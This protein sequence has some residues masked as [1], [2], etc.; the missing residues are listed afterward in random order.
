MTI[1]Q[2]EQLAKNHFGITASAELLACEFGGNF[3][4]T[5]SSGDSF[6]L[7][8]CT[9]F[10]QVQFPGSGDVQNMKPGAVFS[11]QFNSKGT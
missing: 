1:Q 10:K 7:K 9:L 4:L 5:D 11:G 6:L 2:I 8:I 3:K